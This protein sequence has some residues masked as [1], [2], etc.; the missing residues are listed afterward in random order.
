[1]KVL[2]VLS[3]LLLTT[4]V[5]HSEAQY[6]SELLGGSAGTTGSG[7]ETTVSNGVASI[8]DKATSVVKD[9]ATSTANGVKDVV[10]QTLNGIKEAFASALNLGHTVP[11]QEGTANNGSSGFGGSVS[12]LLAKMLRV[13]RSA[14]TLN[15]LGDDNAVDMA[16]TLTLDLPTVKGAFVRCD[17]DNSGSLDDQEVLTFLRGIAAES[18]AKSALKM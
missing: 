13:K 14:L 17:V 18:L 12:G 15:P 4:M 5:Q 8:T 10:R 2:F 11:N 1:M 3:L 6:L 7:V 16:I 9:T